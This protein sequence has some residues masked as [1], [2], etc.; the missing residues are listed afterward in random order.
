MMTPVMKPS[1][2]MKPEDRRRHRRIAAAVKVTYTI[3]SDAN[4]TPCEYGNTVTED[5]SEGGLCMLIH[6][7]ITEGRLVYVNIQIPT[8]ESSLLMLAK[9]VRVTPDA[10]SKMNRSC[11]KFVG[12]LPVGLRSLMEE[13]ETAAEGEMV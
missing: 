13:I 7:D 11:M 4:A 2:E 3:L 1:G 8:H 10:E 6:E 12:M 9:T 5:I